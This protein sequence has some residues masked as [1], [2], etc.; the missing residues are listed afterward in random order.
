MTIGAPVTTSEDIQ[1]KVRC[2]TDKL[3]EAVL[4]EHTFEDVVTILTGE[5]VEAFELVEDVVNESAGVVLAVAVLPARQYF[6]CK[7]R[8]R[9]TVGNKSTRD[10]YFVC[11]DIGVQY[12]RARSDE[13]PVTIF[14]ND[15]DADNRIIE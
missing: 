3:V 15:R 6:V 8:T 10:D 13:A 14:L 2:I 7:S 4:V 9:D 11:T 12:N 5:D 1:Q